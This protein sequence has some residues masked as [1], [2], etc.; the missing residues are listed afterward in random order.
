M[1]L[2]YW[3]NVSLVE[4][5][6]DVTARH[7]GLVSALGLGSRF[8]GCYRPWSH[9]A[10]ALV[11]TTLTAHDNEI[12]SGYV[13]YSMSDASIRFA[14]PNNWVRGMTWS[15]N[16]DLVLIVTKTTCEVVSGAGQKVVTVANDLGR[17]AV[18]AGWTPSG[19]WFF[20]AGPGLTGAPTDLVF[21]SREGHEAVRIPLDPRELAPYDSA[22]YSKLD[23][24]GY[25]LTLS[26]GLRAVGRGLDEWSDCEF[27]P[28]RNALIVCVL[29]PTS[30]VAPLSPLRKQ[31]SDEPAQLG[32]TVEKRW[33]RAEVID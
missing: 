17:R 3:G 28:E 27:D 21:Y 8:L 32:C 11:V 20:C 22:L 10:G 31:E 29:R 25:C 16:E 9:D 13:L 2:G 19:A 15:P 24:D 6:Q 7:P 5:G 12:Q 26:P 33:L 23:R 30:E 14:E 4:R 1:G 18:I